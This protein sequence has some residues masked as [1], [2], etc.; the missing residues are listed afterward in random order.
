MRQ[1][2]MHPILFKMGP[3]TLRTYGL[4]VSMG[5]ILAVSLA[6][7]EARRQGLDGQ[8]IL[9]LGFY[10]LVASIIGSRLLYVLISYRD[11]LARPWAIFK[12][13]EGGLV[14]F[15]GF[16]LAAPIG[17][18]FIKRHGLPLWKTADLWA[19]PLALAHSL[20]RI[21]CFSA[22]CCYGKPTESPLAVTFFDPQSLAVLGVPLHPVQL[23]ES[24]AN[25]LLFLFLSFYWPHRRYDGQVF[26]LYALLYSFIRFFL[27]FLRGDSRGFIIPSLLSTSQGLS[28]LLAGASLIMLLRLRRRA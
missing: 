16:A 1:I 11:Y 3:L 12:I 22:G 25:L 9:D 18:W 23:Y 20:G 14:F 5:V 19:A 21:G 10:L 8:K 26:W 13:W 28:I 2:F 15:G 4:F 17:I 24:F 6:V 7:R 27:E